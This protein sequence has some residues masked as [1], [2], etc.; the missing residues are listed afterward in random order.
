MCKANQTVLKFIVGGF[1]SKDW[2]FR[3]M[4]LGGLIRVPRKEAEE[5]Q[6]QFNLLAMMQGAHRGFPRHISE[7]MKAY[8][9]SKCEISFTIHAVNLNQRAYAK[10]S[11]DHDLY[12]LGITLANLIPQTE[13]S[14]GQT[15]FQARDPGIDSRL[16]FNVWHDALPHCAK[17]IRAKGNANELDLADFLDIKNA[18]MKGRLQEGAEL[19]RAALARSPD[20]AYFYYAQTLEAAPIDGLRIAKKGMMCTKISPFLRFQMLYRAVEYASELGMKLLQDS[21]AVNKGSWELGVAF[22]TSALE[23]ARTFLDNAPPDNR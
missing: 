4:C 5:D 1:R 2:V 8:G 18:I 7:I 9:Q 13:F 11:D 22:L 14:V 23:V 20:Q 10:C 19:A 15:G 16:P 12:A 17:A 21:G 6:R 3:A